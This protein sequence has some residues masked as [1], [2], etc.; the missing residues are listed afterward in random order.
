MSDQQYLRKV[1]L[2]IGDDSGKA[3][4]LSEL[5]VVFRVMQGRVSTPH[6]ADVRVYNVG[7]ETSS[8]VRNEFTRL[9]LQAGYESS[10]MATL[11]NGTL[12]QKRLG[13]E[14]GVDT[15][16]DLMA[17]DGD[18]PF[19]QAT[20]NTTL[21]PGATLQDVHQSILKSLY[22]FGIRQGQTA[23]FPKQSLSRGKSMYGMVRD[24]LDELARSTGT[25][26][27]FSQGALNMLPQLGYLGDPTKAVVLTRDTGLIGMPAQTIDGINVRCLLNARITVGTLIQLD[28]RS[29]QLAKYN[30]DFKAINENL[31]D[32]SADGI[33]QVLSVNHYG[34]T[35][36][37]EWYTEMICSSINGTQ[38]MTAA[39][40]TATP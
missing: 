21:A 20:I 38:P 13:R 35:R 39:T 12:I 31:P 1:S 6:Y 24:Y 11:L 3:L 5:R 25:D 18:E 23:E 33:Y 19:N 30:P 9:Y 29:I 7:S 28:N 8:K 37:Q 4:D 22:N 16:L 34:D 10:G 15:F 14:N 36:G 40:I 2:L 17:A 32:L 26:W 27:H